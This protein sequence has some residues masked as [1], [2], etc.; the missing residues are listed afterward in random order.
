[1]TIS[2][3]KDMIVR[4]KKYD[5]KSINFFLCKPMMY[6]FFHL[7]EYIVETISDSVD[8]RSNMVMV[9]CLFHIKKDRVK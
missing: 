1:M 5:E 2:S 6:F 7:L 9:R 4:F 3:I 8:S